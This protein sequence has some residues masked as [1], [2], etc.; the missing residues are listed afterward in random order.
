M[1]GDAKK[2]DIATEH[3]LDARILAWFIPSP[4]QSVLSSLKIPS[5]DLIFILYAVTGAEPSKGTWFHYKITLTSEL[6]VVAVAG[7]FG[8]VAIR[9]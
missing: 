6:V 7:G 9:T 1:N 8:I 3:Y 2:T 4:P 5:F